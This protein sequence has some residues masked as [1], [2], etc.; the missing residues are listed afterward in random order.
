MESLPEPVQNQVLENLR[1]YLEEMQNEGDWD[2]LVGKNQ[3]KLIE[4]A[5]KSRSQITEGL[6][7]PLDETR[8]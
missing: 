3:S 2:T 4:A 8:L 7:E 6:S 5:R 1:Y